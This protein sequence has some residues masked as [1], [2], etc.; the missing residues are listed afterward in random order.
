MKVERTIKFM[1][2]WNNINDKD[3]LELVIYAILIGR[4]IIC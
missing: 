1:I 3:Y 4:Y 2:I